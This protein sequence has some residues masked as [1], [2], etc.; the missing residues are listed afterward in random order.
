MPQA[1]LRLLKCG[2][3]GSATQSCSSALVHLRLRN[4]VC[5][6][7]FGSV[8]STKSTSQVR[9]RSIQGMTLEHRDAVDPKPWKIPNRSETSRTSNS[10]SAPRHF[11]RGLLQS[12]PPS[13][14]L[15][16]DPHRRK[17]HY[18]LRMG[19]QGVGSRP[20]W[21]YQGTGPR[22]RKDMESAL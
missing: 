16:A 15:L 14:E 13:V 19:F 18:Q 22:A 9:I 8:F 10:C 3:S 12:P 7:H 2:F 6:V 1:A 4:L 17:N 20:F 5:P 11:S 21:L